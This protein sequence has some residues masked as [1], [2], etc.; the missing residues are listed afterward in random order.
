[1]AL[2]KYAK[3]GKNNFSLSG[4]ANDADYFRGFTDYSTH[5]SVR[6][7]RTLFIFTGENYS[8]LFSNSTVGER[9]DLIRFKG[10]EKLQFALTLNIVEAFGTTGLYHRWNGSQFFYIDANGKETPLVTLGTLENGWGS[11]PEV[12]NK[13]QIY[14]SVAVDDENK[15]AYFILIFSSIQYGVGTGL[16][17]QPGTSIIELTGSSAALKSMLYN[18]ATNNGAEY[19][20]DPW[21][22]G[23]YGDIGGGDGELDLSSDVIGL[24]E[25]PPSFVDTGFVQIFSPALSEVR[26]L[27]DYMWNGN[28]FEQFLKLFSDPMQIIIGLSMYPFPI[29]T[30]GKKLV[31]AGN[32][33]TTVY[34]SYPT[35]QYVTIDCGTIDVKHFYDAYLD[36]EP[37]T[38]CQIFLPY[39]G[40]HS[41]SMDDIMGKTVQVVYRVDLMTGV[42]GAYILCDGIL[43]Y[44]FTGECSAQIPVSGTSYQSIIQSAINITT[45]TAIA[46]GKQKKSDGSTAP[47]QKPQALA[48]S[49]A[50][51]VM[52]IKPDVA[53][54]GSVGGNVGMLGAQKPYLIFS[55]PRTCLPKGQNKYLGYPT[56]MTVKLSEVEG[57][58]EIE[59]VRLNNMTCTEEE[60]I[61]IL[62]I[63]KEGVI[64]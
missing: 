15:Q 49:L 41:L 14:F 60:K 61:E 20:P 25:L 2:T 11:T 57:Y 29:P 54:T 55:V 18:V 21:S 19:D 16:D 10:G 22:N 27:S 5:K 30:V 35:S 8:D 23:G 59:N 13:G 39:I 43:L 62:Q 46:P 33:V 36:Y 56:F 64:L 44:T 17:R 40:V 38:S 7:P 34:M 45:A 3:I 31:H 48:S 4:L 52:S 51:N 1:M 37:Y 28:F 53:R 12:S 47:S 6:D 58:T 26:E 50:S 42:C 9:V 24:P 32:I 63:L